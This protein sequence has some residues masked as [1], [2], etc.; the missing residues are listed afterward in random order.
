MAAVVE[1]TGAGLTPDEVIAVARQ[2]ARVVLADTAR[3]AM[4]RSA[5]GVARGV[6]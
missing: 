2:E 1:L 5:A 6:E 4:G 3:S